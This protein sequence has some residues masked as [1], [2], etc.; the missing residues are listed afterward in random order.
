VIVPPAPG[1]FSALGSLISDLRRDYVRPRL[2]HTRRGTLAEVE[3]VFA[4]LEREARDDLAGEGFTPEQTSLIRTL[5]MRYVGQ[6]WELVVRAPAGADSVAAFERA[7]HDAHERRY[8]HASDQPAE[9]VN[10]RLTAVGAV[11]KPAPR[12]WAV[13]GTLA[14]AQ[15]AERAVFF[16]DAPRPAPVYARDRL[17]GGV[18]VAGPAVV[19]EMGATTVIPPG[20][21]GTVGPWGELV[22]ERRSL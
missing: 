18:A 9:I 8:G 16:D 6:S 20:W 1:N 11:P 13:A 14:E 4:E 19:E 7:F 3:G 17:P 2:T 22:L 5:G 15:R 10:F 12:R 21:R